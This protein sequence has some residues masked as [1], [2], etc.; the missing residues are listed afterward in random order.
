EQMLPTGVIP[1]YKKIALPLLTALEGLGIPAEITGPEGRGG[2]TGVCFA[3]QNA[4]E[5]S[6]GGKKVI[7]SAQVRRNGFVL[8]HGSILLS[9]D[10]EKHSR[11]MKGRHSLDP[12]VLASKMT[13]LETIMGKKVTLQK[14]TDLIAIAFE[15]VFE[16]ELLY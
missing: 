1:S 15:K 2:R 13:G 3:Q 9:V 7:G 6:V 16:T 14:L 5:I 8:Q 10:Y 12:A 11:C 4:Y